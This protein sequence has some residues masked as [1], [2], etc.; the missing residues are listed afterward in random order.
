MIG[1]FTAF[2]VLSMDV[3]HIASALPMADDQTWFN[4]PV[5]QQDLLKAT[6]D[7]LYMV[8]ASTLATVVFGVPLGVILAETRKG[9]IAQ[10]RMVNRVLGLLVNTGRAIPFIILAVIV[11]Y[12]IR[13]IDVSW[14]SA[15]GWKAFAIA[16]TVSA[17]P[18]FARM[19]ESNVLAVSPGKVEAAQMA[20][21]SNVAIMAGVLVREALPS[22]VQ[23]IT[24]LTITIIGYAAMGGSLGAGGLGALAINHG[25]QRN[26]FDVVV[27]TTVVILI[28]VFIIQW[29][30]DMLSRLVD[31]R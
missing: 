4:R 24:I 14:L 27:I 2:D 13:A 15:I 18:Y 3:A 11:L 28:M 7:T 8:F 29:I 12:A 17:V 19:V 23:S 31:H 6:I 20:G 5:I 21:A 1:F 26:N 16:L 30:G 22:I 25:Y 10:N 9:G